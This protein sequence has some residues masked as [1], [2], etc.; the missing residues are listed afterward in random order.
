M[1]GI[2]RP[3]RILPFLARDVTRLLLLIW[4]SLRERSVVL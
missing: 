4:C 1:P 3:L 2:L